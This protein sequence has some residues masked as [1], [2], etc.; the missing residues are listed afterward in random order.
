M[1][2]LFFFDEK[3]P[4]QIFRFFL[5]LSHTIKKAQYGKFLM[6]FYS[7][8]C[9]QK[10][11]FA[12]KIIWFGGV[13]SQAKQSYKKLHGKVREAVVKASNALR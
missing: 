6:I 1:A 2:V 12:L 7:F 10:N 4:L 13:Q 3:K 8:Y 11:I 9:S 5:M